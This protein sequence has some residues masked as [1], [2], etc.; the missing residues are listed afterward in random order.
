MVGTISPTRKRH[1][2]EAYKPPDAQELCPRTRSWRP[3]IQNFF[4]QAVREILRSHVVAV[5][6]SGSGFGALCLTALGV[7]GVEL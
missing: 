6:I 4:G 7:Y 1:S 2:P 3:G 5:P